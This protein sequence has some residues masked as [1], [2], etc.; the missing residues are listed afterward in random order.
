MI[1]SHTWGQDSARPGCLYHTP[2]SL[3]FI[4]NTTVRQLPALN[5]VSTSFLKDQLIDT[6]VYDWYASP[7]S[8]GAFAMFGPDEFSTVMPALPKPA[9]HGKMHFAEEALSSGHVWIIGAVNSACRTIAEILAVE[10]RGDL[11]NQSVETWGTIGEV[12]MG[13]YTQS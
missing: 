2:S 1:A 11:L 10:G 6:H 8:V 3:D 12:D 5:N 9:F 13:W 4:T 7:Y